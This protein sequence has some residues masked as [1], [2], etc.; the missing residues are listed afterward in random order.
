MYAT[1]ESYRNAEKGYYPSY[2]TGTIQFSD[3]TTIEISDSDIST[4]GVEITMQAATQDILEFG[5][6][7]VGQL[8]LSLRTSK[9]DS[10]Y[11]YYNAVITLN[12][13]IELPDG[14]EVIPL[15]IWTV[16]EADRK[17]TTLK[18]SA[19]DNLIK[20]DK[21][22]NV[23]VTGQPFD[24]MSQIAQEC[25]CELAEDENYYKTLPNNEELIGIMT[26]GACS[27]YRQAATAIAQ[28]CGCFVQADRFGKISMKQ[29]STTP[30]FSL[31][32]SQ[33]YECVLADYLC[34]YVE[35][36]V[37]SVQGTFQSI[38]QVVESG[39]TLTMNDALAWDDGLPETL[40]RRTDA[41]M[42]LLDQIQYTPGELSIPSDPSI[43]CGD[44][45]AIETETGTVNTLVTSYTWKYHA[46]MELESVGKN[47]RLFSTN[48]SKQQMLKEVEQKSM[49]N[50]YAFKNIK[51]F[52]C[53]SELE[54]FVQVTFV[55]TKETF[56]LFSGTFQVDVEVDDV[57]Y[58]SKLILTK[59]DEETGE[60]I[61]EEHNIPFTRAGHVD[62]HIQYQYNGVEFGPKYIHT[63]EKGSHIITLHYPIQ[64]IEGDSIG[65]FA[66]YMSVEGGNAHI[67]KEMFM[68]TISGQGL[69][70]NP[71]WDGTINFTEI[72]PYYNI[73]DL[74]LT[75]TNINDELA[76]SKSTNI[77]KSDISQR[78]GAHRLADLTLPIIGF[79]ES[80]GF[81]EV[82][83]NYTV[84]GAKA[85]NYDF[86]SEY[87]TF[88]NGFALRTL[89]E[90]S[91]V[92]ETIDTG[93][94]CS[95]MIKTDDKA[96]V[97]SVVISE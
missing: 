51:R 4:G 16:S 90:Y 47:P 56:A 41:L 59:T 26:G 31:T 15:G 9:Y 60:T 37:T 43:D 5:P 89:Y 65:R 57:E 21:A 55:S 87:V 42:L 11:R 39:T 24:I 93:K 95:I 40:Q 38:S 29:F 14:V 33:R 36:V 84:E 54:P 3:N 75:M 12:Y 22:F 61:T 96:N 58:T 82:V 88:E 78:I 46:P 7:V 85:E 91:S 83:T 49:A 32:A 48:S 94:M 73:E 50:L 13:N 18:L 71:K 74:S 28:L 79:T 70:G 19:Y 10:R 64:G 68:G 2:L 6:A 44:Y 62:L 52:D 1:S 63:L 45:I 66:I 92:E 8:D 35:L 86:N 80:I 76:V 27:T 30:T 67:K 72:L 97:E 20:L 69:A 17:G 25:E 81:S 53:T 23:S 34:R 77:R